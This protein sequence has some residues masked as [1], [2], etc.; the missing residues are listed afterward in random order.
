MHAYLQDFKQLKNK[1]INKLHSLLQSMPILDPMSVCVCV[2]YIQV[3]D[4][5][6]GQCTIDSLPW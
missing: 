4:Q 3:I 5:V 1:A 6:I 2:Q